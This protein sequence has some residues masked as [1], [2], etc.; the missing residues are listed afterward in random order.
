MVTRAEILSQA[1]ADFEESP[2]ISM[3]NEAKVQ[4]DQKTNYAIRTHELIN[5]PESEIEDFVPQDQ[6]DQLRAYFEKAENPQAEREKFIEVDM[7]SLSTG[8]PDSVANTMHS[9]LKAD[10]TVDAIKAE[11]TGERPGFFKRGLKKFGRSFV[12]T[13]AGIRTKSNFGRT[14]T[15]LA[16]F[17]ERINTAIEAGLIPKGSGFKE[18][19]QIPEGEVDELFGGETI[20]EHIERKDIERAGQTPGLDITAV[21]PAEGVG[22]KIADVAGN[23]AGFVGKL[24]LTKRVL[25]PG[26]GQSLVAWETVNLAE[27][28]FPGRGAAM[29]VALRGIDKIRLKGKRVFRK[30]R[31]TVQF[32]CRSYRS[33]RWYS[34]RSFYR[35]S[36]TVGIKSG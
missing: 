36:D 3:L 9:E 18:F 11:W 24:A 1:Q 32:V 26:Q 14:M 21:P 25:G 7:L 13:L 33:G 12:D 31:Y 2:H 30:D 16:V 23:V 35:S 5:N 17:N 28:G 19:L 22:E 8:M 29:F 10:G 15:D 6:A 34:R 27:G 20:L 4:L